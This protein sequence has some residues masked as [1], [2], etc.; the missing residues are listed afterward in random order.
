[1]KYCGTLISVSDMKKSR[2]FYEKV[3][4][5]EV[6]IDLGVHV[7]FVNGFSLQSNYKELVGE[8]LEMHSKPN[9]FQLYFEVEDLNSWE[10][11]LRS[12]E[13]IEFIHQSKEYPWGQR[14]M[15]FYDHD[16]YI[17]EVSESMESV[18][19]RFSAQGLTVE[20]IAERTMF[21]VELVKQ[22]L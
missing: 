14:V 11:K 10:K 7:S 5:Q 3:M 20:E 13:G 9:N 4:D 19:R 6:G 2:D 8:K 22:L 1:M 17:V 12:V 16:Q 21:P 15:R 18:V